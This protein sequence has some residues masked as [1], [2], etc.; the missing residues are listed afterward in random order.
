M[1]YQGS[2]YLHEGIANCRDFLL[3]E[4]IGRLQSTAPCW[5]VSFIYK[6]TLMLDSNGHRSLKCPNFC[7]GLWPGAYFSPTIAAVS[8]LHSPPLRVWFL[9]GSFE[10]LLYEYLRHYL[11]HS[12][13]EVYII[14]ES[15]ACS[16][17]RQGRLHKS[18]ST[19]TYLHVALWQCRQLAWN[20]VTR[21]NK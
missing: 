21:K 10:R 11:A 14:H 8:S 9:Q 18:N 17:Q 12:R 6:R 7:S 19:L 3:P 5:S 2:P 4:M 1:S 13:A 15:C 16:W 20:S